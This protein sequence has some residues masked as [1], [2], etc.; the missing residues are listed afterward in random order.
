M[1]TSK[2]TGVGMIWEHDLLLYMKRAQE[3]EVAVDD[4]AWRRARVAMLT[5]V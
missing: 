4:A 5:N 1:P 3:S 2:F